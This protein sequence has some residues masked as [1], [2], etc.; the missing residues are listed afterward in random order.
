M[1]ASGGNHIPFSA[2]SLRP[3]YYYSIY[4]LN[5]R[6]IWIAPLYNL[7]FIH[8]F[9]LPYI[10][11]NLIILFLVQQQP[12]TVNTRV[13]P[14]FPVHASNEKEKN[15]MKICQMLITFIVS[16]SDPSLPSFSIT[17]IVSDPNPALLWGLLPSL[18]AA[19]SNSVFVLYKF[20]GSMIWNIIFIVL[21]ITLRMCCDMVHF[22]EHPFSVE[23]LPMNNISR[24]EC[25]SSSDA[26]V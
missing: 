25:L 22:R 5:P 2:S 8:C 6:L 3:S 9:S 24:Q 10:L 23:N 7:L 12:Q 1:Q 16:I 14:C 11:L 20:Q 13:I 19:L 15:K 26:A 21:Y 17:L 4:K 18:P